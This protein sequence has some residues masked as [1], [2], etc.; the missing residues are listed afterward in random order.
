MIPDLVDI[1][2]SAPWSVLPPGIFKTTVPEI[3]QRFAITPHRRWLFGGLVRA[4]AAFEAAGCRRLYVDGSFVTAKPHPE[5]YDGCWEHDGI[6]FALLDPVLLKFD[7]KREAQ[8]Q[9]Y[10]GEMFPAQAEGATGMT[11]L[12]LFQNEKYSGRPKGILRVDLASKVR[13]SP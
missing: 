3:A 10:L 5:D 12:Q 7:N 9:K 8:K 2:G 6:D 11:F 13:R 4:V 1:G